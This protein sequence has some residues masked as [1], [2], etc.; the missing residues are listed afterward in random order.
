MLCSSR[1]CLLCLGKPELW[2]QEERKK[3]RKTE[4]EDCRQTPT[5]RDR[6]TQNVQQSPT[7]TLLF[8]VHDPGGGEGDLGGGPG[9]PRA[10]RLAHRAPLLDA[11]GGQRH[12][13]VGGRGRADRRQLRLGRHAERH[14]GEQGGAA[15]IAGRDAR[16]VISF[17]TH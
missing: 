6:S 3:G 12:H 8:Q 5:K 7:E 1:S 9:R 15:R 17:T 2:K 4:K 16:Q 13:E 10:V 14:R 11:A